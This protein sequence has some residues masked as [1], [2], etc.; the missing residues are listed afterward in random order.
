M[1]VGVGEGVGVA[2]A[3][4]VGVGVGV[5]V[6]VDVGLG[7]G[8]G[9][10]EATPTDMPPVPPDAELVSSPPHATRARVK[11]EHRLALARKPARW[12]AETD[13]GVIDPYRNATCG[14]ALVTPPMP[15][16]AAQWLRNN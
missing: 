13:I 3:V 1:G 7:L 12:V 6:A 16:F 10:G 5:G 4:G 11:A 15:P 14:F 2:V 9:V 8:L